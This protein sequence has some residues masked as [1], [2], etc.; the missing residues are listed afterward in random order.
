MTTRSANAP[1]RH[2]NHLEGADAGE[3]LAVLVD[4][5]RWVR[6]AEERAHPLEPSMSIMQGAELAARAMCAGHIV[7]IDLPLRSLHVPT[8]VT[9]RLGPW[10]ELG[11]YVAEL[12]ES[13]QH[14]L[15]AIQERSLYATREWGARMTGVQMTLRYLASAAGDPNLVTVQQLVAGLLEHLGCPE[16]V[17]I[18]LVRPTDRVMAAPQAEVL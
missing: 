5:V 15:D 10:S 9:G 13:I 18:P 16:F 6:L 17:P 1:G 14:V 2:G 7:E 4:A 12:A 8:V 3:V 11:P